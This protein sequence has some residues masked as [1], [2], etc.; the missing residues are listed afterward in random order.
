VQRKCPSTLSSLHCNQSERFHAAKPLFVV[1][2]SFVVPGVAMKELDKKME[3]KKMS[4]VEPQMDTDE[5]I[6]QALARAI[7]VYL[8]IC[9]S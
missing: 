2:Q 5:Q 9:G 3:D 7:C 6:K 8:S 1:L 4:S